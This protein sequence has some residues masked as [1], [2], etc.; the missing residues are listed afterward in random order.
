V[1]AGRH[2]LGWLVVGNAAGLWLSLLLLFPGLNAG[3]W[4]YGRWVP[5]HLNVQ[6]YGWTALP[7]VAWLL[8]IYDVPRRWAEAATWA[9]TVALAAG[10]LSWL[11]G[12]SSG[13]IF[14]DWKGG[15][16]LA[17]VT[18]LAF[19]WCVLAAGWWSRR[20]S[21]SPLKRRSSLAG[22]AV[23]ALV[24]WGMLQASSPQVYPPVNPG[25]GGPT[26]A[27]LL[28]STLVVVGLLMLLPRASG[29]ERKRSGTPWGT[30]GYFA[31]CWVVFIIAEA[32]GGNHY[33]PLQIIALGLLLPWPWLVLRDWRTFCWA[34]R[35]HGWRVA[36][37]LW[38]GLLVVSAWI[39]FLPGILDR[40]KFTHGLVAHSHLAM[41]GFT[42]AFCAL[43]LRLTGQRF[44]RLSTA[45]AWN[46]AALTMVVVLAA[47]GWGESAGVAWMAEAPMWRT[48]A[49]VVRTLCGLVMLG[50]SIHWWIS[51]RPAAFPI[52]HETNRPALERGRRG[53][54][55]RD[56]SSA[57]PDTVAGDETALNPSAASGSGSVHGLDRSLRA[58]HGP[59][60]QSLPPEGDDG[61]NRVDD[62]GDRSHRG[63]NLSRREHRARHTAGGM[64]GGG[65]DRRG[66]GG[67]PSDRAEDGLLAGLSLPLR[68]AGVVAMVYAHFLIFAQF[69]WVELMRA[70]GGS[71]VTEKIA[72][73]T[74]TLAGITAGFVIARRDTT[75]GVLRTAFI[76]AA[77][78]AAVSPWASSVPFALFI[79]LLSG[80]SIGTMT[81]SLAP[82]LP[83]WCGIAWVGLGTGIGYALCNFPPVFL[84]SPAQQAA[85]GAAFALFGATLVPRES[86]PFPIVGNATTRH[87]MLAVIAA[88]TA[89]VWLDSAAFFII[90]HERDLKSATWGE[91]LLWRNAV[92]HLA[93]AVLAGLTLRRGFS[94]L[95][96]IAWAILATAAFAVNDPATRSLAGW[97][98]PVGVSL[99]STALV[100]W[101]GF[102]SPDADPRAVARRAAWLYAIAG[103]FGSANGIGMVQ[104][105]HHVPP[106]FIIIAGAV[107]L[108]TMLLRRNQWPVGVAV[109][110]MI[111]LACIQPPQPKPQP[112][113]IERGRAVYLA[114]GCIHCHSRYVRPGSPDEL[115][116]GPASDLTRVLAEKPVLIGNRRQGPD[117]ANVG[118]RRSEAWLKLHFL[119]PRD[120]SPD[121]PMPSYAHLFKDTRGD[122]LIAFLHD[123]PADAISSR[124]RTAATWTPH[125]T[126]TIPHGAPLF[127]SHC[128]ACHGVVGHGDG[129]FASVL[130]KRPTDLNR[131][132]FV[133]TPSGPDLENRVARAIKFGL[134][135]TD[136]PG[137]ETLD[138]ARIVALARYIAYLRKE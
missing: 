65:G 91:P 62:D 119:N 101:P 136:M 107:V 47:T 34:E 7:L 72:L 54:G 95:L 113:A 8:S 39:A 92:M 56:G 64:V 18:A 61:G 40:M 58:L 24:P 27:S 138:D 66:G 23:L 93:A 5:V 57:D 21:W 43:L 115:L 46:V 36:M 117:L 111:F 94:T 105:L 104:S 84:A 134:P 87:G 55:R 2:A 30:L 129:K 26:G 44:G 128:A 76:A 11:G 132:P 100:A 71:P 41:A 45:V 135:G 10:V 3:E 25:S 51:W 15:S 52:T 126:S 42:T 73:G 116:W 88:F 70:A 80:A 13:K 85:I 112:T 29:L 86:A 17:F 50:A 120:F 125:P 123:V 22:L 63:R 74:M 59:L 19:L 130:V 6:L 81:V 96:A 20:R 4:T 31:A 122:D 35:P 98:Y 99:Y 67:G 110:A 133:W 16:L 48:A 32:I 79:S 114:E 33:D 90:Q 108:G 102:F 69:A 68:A 49:L 12:I 82:L 103:W 127:L 37:L 89:L 83:R 60:L 106:M 97:I 75:P 28:G 78:S 77:I 38:W 1:N 137:H 14:L 124:A 53:D 131:G 109:V 121:S 9:W 118:A